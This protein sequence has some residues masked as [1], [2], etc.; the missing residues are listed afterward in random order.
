MSSGW[1]KFRYKQDLAHERAMQTPEAVLA[2]QTQD[3]LD[4][5]EEGVV[6]CPHCGNVNLN[7]STELCFYCG[8][9]PDEVASA[10]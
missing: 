2:K 9:F 5:L 6:R 4:D 1:A 8:K 10:S 3:D 7:H